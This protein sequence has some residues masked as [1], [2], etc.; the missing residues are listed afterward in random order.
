[1]DHGLKCNIK[2]LNFQLEKIG[3]TLYEVRFGEDFIY[4][5]PQIMIYKRKN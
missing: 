3:E 2:V 5:A 4:L 1:M